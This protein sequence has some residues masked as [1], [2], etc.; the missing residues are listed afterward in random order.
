MK[1]RRKGKEKKGTERRRGLRKHD[2]L[3][4]YAYI[5]FE[6]YVRYFEGGR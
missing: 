5:R 6:G 3:C 1:M 4:L 2:C